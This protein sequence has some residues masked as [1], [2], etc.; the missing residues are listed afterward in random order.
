MARFTQIDYDRE[1]AFIATDMTDQGH[2]ETLGVVRAI[3]DPDDRTAEFAI[4]VRAELKGQGLGSA[5][6]EKIIRY[7]RRKGIQTL[8]GEVLADKQS[9]LALAEKIGFKRQPTADTTTVS[10]KL[11]LSER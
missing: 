1:M 3:A 6:L 7:C 11:L 2:A 10:L 5:L 9:M 8:V 4:I